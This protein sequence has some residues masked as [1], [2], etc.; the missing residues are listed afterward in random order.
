MS[1]GDFRSGPNNAAGQRAHTRLVREIVAGLGSCPDLALHVNPV[2]E[3]EVSS[4]SK[5]GTF[6]QRHQTV[7]LGPG[8]PDIVGMLTIQT[9]AV[10]FCLEAK[11]GTGTLNPRQREWH[12][13]MLQRGVLVYTVHS[14]GEA[15][16]A[17]T[18]ARERVRRALGRGL[19]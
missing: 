6:H 7:G 5:D 18:D 10:W 4:V 13:A 1:A 19:P 12:S 11:T 14:V 8:S 16:A 17:L 9:L 2:G 3:A 15:W